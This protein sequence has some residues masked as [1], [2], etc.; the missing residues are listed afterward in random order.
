[1]RF[2]D[3]VE[4]WWGDYERSL[5]RRGRSEQ[6]IAVSRRSFERFWTWRSAAA[7]GPTRLAMERNAINAWVDSRAGVTEKR[8]DP[9]AEH[10]AVLRVMGAKST[11]AIPSPKADTPGAPTVLVPVVALDDIRKI[12][13]VCSGESFEERRDTAILYVL[14]VT[15]GSA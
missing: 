10:A 3:G 12:L 5:R 11:P 4:G 9:V 15:G 1:M 2:P 6:T 8:V 7:S 14:I 13:A